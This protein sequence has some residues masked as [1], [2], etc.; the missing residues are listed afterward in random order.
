MNSKKHVLVIVRIDVKPEMEEEFNRWYDQEHIPNL[1]TVPGVL[2]AKRGVNTGKGPKYVAVYEHES[3]DVQHTEA[4]RKAVDTDWTR[5][6]S[7]HFSKMEREV[8]G[9]L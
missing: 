8:Y 5:K 6:L 3:I 1:L 2:W 9:L 4:F 7:P